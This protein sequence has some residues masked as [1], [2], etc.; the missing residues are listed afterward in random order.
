MIRRLARVLF[1]KSSPPSAYSEWLLDELYAYIAATYPETALPKPRFI[2]IVRQYQ[3]PEWTRQANRYIGDL[4]YAFAPDFAAR[5]GDYYRYTDLQLTLTLF[6]Y[7][8]NAALLEANFLRPYRVASERLGRFSILE[9]GAGLPHGILHGVFSGNAASYSSITT[10]DIDGVPARFFEFFC[11]RHRIDHRWI[12]AAAGEA[13]RLSGGPFDFVFAKDVF[14][15]LTN[16]LPALDEV[17]RCAS[18]R[19]MLALDLEDK[20]AVV[21]QHVSPMLA[22]LRD[23][24]SAAGFTLI[25]Q[26]GN[27]LLYE[28]RPGASG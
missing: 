19:A 27:L 7:S 14:E 26:T 22:P 5:L 15:H 13:A 11:R 4:W 3:D 20:G 17:L 24:V 23:G 16:P 21:Y 9:L 12:T 6:A 28:R 1:K 10:V 18:S 25:E 2:Q 8:T